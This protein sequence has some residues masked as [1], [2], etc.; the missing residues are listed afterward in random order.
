MKKPIFGR[1]IAL[2]IKLI[3]AKTAK[4]EIYKKLLT[5]RF[6]KYIFKNV[7]EPKIST[8][9]ANIS[10]Y[11]TFFLCCPISTIIIDHVCFLNKILSLILL[12]NMHLYNN[13]GKGKDQICT[14]FIAPADKPLTIL[15]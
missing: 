13:S 3:A 9:I 4:I 8:M 11:I 15:L 5:G 14:Y 12:H 10:R 1:S 2:K 6:T 7:N